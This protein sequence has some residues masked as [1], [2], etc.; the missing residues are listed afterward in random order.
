[1]L[2]TINV[3]VDLPDFGIIELPLVYKMEEEKPGVYLVSCK[4]TLSAEKLPEW[5]LTTAFNI[6]YTQ[7]RD[8]NANIVSV[9]TDNGTTNRYHEIMLSIVSS[10]IKLKEDGIGLNLPQMKTTNVIT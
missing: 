4:I 9:S 5:L 10:Y 1:M 6:V 8:E 3:L 7:V 2:K